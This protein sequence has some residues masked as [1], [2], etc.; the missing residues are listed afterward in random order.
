[1]KKLI[2][3]T[4]QLLM[5][6]AF[7]QAQTIG[8][9]MPVKPSGSEVGV[10]QTLNFAFSYSGCLG[11][12]QVRVTAMY[13]DNVVNCTGNP[14]AITDE[15]GKGSAQ[16]V[17][18]EPCKTNQIRVEF[19]RQSTFGR[20]V[21]LSIDT[22][23]IAYKVSAYFVDNIEFSRPTPGYLATSEEVTV[24][25]DYFK[26]YENATV[27]FCPY[28]DGTV[29]SNTTYSA[30]VYSDTV[31]H[32]EATFLINEAVDFNQIKV[33]MENRDSQGDIFYEDIIDVDYKVKDYYF[34]N[35]TLT[36]ETPAVLDVSDTIS[37]SYDFVKKDTT[38]NY[39]FYTRLYSNGVIQ[40]NTNHSD[41]FTTKQLSGHNI[42]TFCMLSA[43]TI[44]ELRISINEANVIRR[45][46]LYEQSVS[47]NFVYNTATSVKQNQVD[48]ERDIWYNQL[49][50]NIKVTHDGRANVSVYNISGQCVMSCFLNEDENV[51]AAD[52]I[53]SGIYL[54]LVKDK[55]GNRS[56]KIV[57][58]R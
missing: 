55:S 38:K 57:I 33:I 46:P 50:Q 35:I 31:G 5:F 44:D 16:L 58:N 18:N 53:K 42:E 47:V 48:V 2:F 19:Y 45:I 34:Y 56:A 36:P 8:K 7:F 39:V 14:Y 15:S 13:R 37:L 1:M 17:I 26:A 11:N 32:G 25:F 49:E 54:V 29:L 28:N 43:V 30:L 21:I 40:T 41:A 12:E 10:G 6:A 9:I 24:S 27:V 22:L 52:N 51:I 23:D 3:T 20:P 4:L